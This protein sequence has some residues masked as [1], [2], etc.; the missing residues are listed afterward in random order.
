MKTA[1]F[2]DTHTFHEEW[3]SQLREDIREEFD[4]AEMVIFTG[5]YSDLGSRR[6]TNSF[7]SWFHHRPNR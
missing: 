2:S 6:D 3:Y 7:L 4:S 1:F 5:D